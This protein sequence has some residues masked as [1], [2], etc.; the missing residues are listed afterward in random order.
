[1]A[2]NIFK[3]KYTPQEVPKQS[4]SILGTPNMFKENK[5]KGLI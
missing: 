5:K 1:M 3:Q 2:P 4:F